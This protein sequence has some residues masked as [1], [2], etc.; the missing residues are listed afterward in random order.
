MTKC[1]VAASVAL[2]LALAGGC[3]GDEDGRRQAPKA[4]APL[5]RELPAWNRAVAAQSCSLYAPLTLTFLRPREARPG[6]PPVGPECQEL[7]AILASQRGVVLQ[8]AQELG[9]AGL[10]SGTGPR[11]GRFTTYTAIFILDWDGRYRAIGVQP[12]EPQIGTRPRDPDA[13]QTTADAFVQAVR[14]RDCTK[15]LRYVMPGAGGFFRGARN[16]RD[17]CRPVLNGRNLAPQ[18]RADADAKPVRLGTTRDLG[19]FA[20]ATKTNYYT[21][22]LQA[23]PRTGVPPALAAQLRGKPPVLVT[24]Y[25]PNQRPV[26]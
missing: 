2:A 11:Q 7:T 6:G 16:P 12:G 17:A 24:D 8:R 26:G 5:S 9:T 25:F 1:T 14:D 20:V 4:K 13:F 18:L 23:R 22:F 15:F 10:A 3:G 21:L 19:F